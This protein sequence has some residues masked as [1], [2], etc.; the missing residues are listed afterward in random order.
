M[1]LMFIS[2]FTYIPNVY[3]LSNM[4]HIFYILSYMTFF[5]TSSNIL[6]ENAD[7][8]IHVTHITR[9]VICHVDS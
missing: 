6:T 9:Y 3:F 8:T 4:P 7:R 2:I 5:L 1:S